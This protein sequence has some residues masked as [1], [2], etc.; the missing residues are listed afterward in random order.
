[1]CVG[2]SAVLDFDKY[3]IGDHT[4]HGTLVGNIENDNIAD[5]DCRLSLDH[6]HI[7]RLARQRKIL[8]FVRNCQSPDGGRKRL[9]RQT[10]RMDQMQER[11]E[12]LLVKGP[13]TDLIKTSS[14]SRYLLNRHLAIISVKSPTSFL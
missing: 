10:T 11:Y 3:S 2:Q 1:L 14:T 8:S 9:G 4:L 6:D 12:G 7:W 13:E 5:K